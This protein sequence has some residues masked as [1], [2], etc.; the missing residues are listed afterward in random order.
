MDERKNT[1][2][3]PTSKGKY[4]VTFKIEAE[5]AVRLNAKR[6]FVIGSWSGDGGWKWDEKQEMNILKNGSFSLTATFE[7]GYYEYKFV[8]E[9]FD[10][11]FSWETDSGM[12]K[13]SNY[14]NSVLFLNPS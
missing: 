6:V 12:L 2:F 14:G 7:P 9:R 5:V 13:S 4:R 10:G 11:S 8:I 1:Y 3:I